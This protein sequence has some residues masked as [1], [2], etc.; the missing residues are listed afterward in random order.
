[1]VAAVGFEVLKLFAT[2]LIGRATNN[3]LYATFGVIVGLLIW[4]NF[5]SKLLMFAAAWTAT[6]PYSLE[7]VVAGEDGAGRSTGL[8]AGTEP[9]SVVAPADFEPVP[10]EQT[11]PGPGRR[12]G[13]RRAA[14]GAA[15]GAS[16]AAAL[17]RRARQR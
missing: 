11:E 7:P 3:P 2:F 13:W 12:G 4:I 6:Q 10:A 8:A 5:V 17:T 9:V 16:V 1:V 15:A 14:I